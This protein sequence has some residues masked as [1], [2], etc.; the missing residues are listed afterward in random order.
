MARMRNISKSSAEY[1][2]GFTAF[3]GIAPLGDHSDK[4][5]LA[6]VENMFRSYE[7]DSSGAIESVPGYRRLLSPEEG[8]EI[9]GVYST[10]H[11][12]LIHIGEGLYHA[13]LAADRQ[14]LD[15][16]HIGELES[17]QSLGF[18]FGGDFYLIDGK[19]VH[20]VG[21]SAENEAA[22]ASTDGTDTGEVA[23]AATQATDGTDTGEVTGAATL[24]TDGTD[25]PIPV[26]TEAEPY[27]PTTGYGGEPYEKRN[28][29]T[30]RFIEEYDIFDGRGY[31]AASEGLRFSVTD[32]VAH[33][34]ALSGADETVGGHLSIPG[35]VIIDGV[36][37]R[38]D[39]ISNGAFRENEKITSVRIAEGVRRIGASAFL[40]CAELTR[41]STP[42]TIEIIDDEALSLC[43]SLTTVYLGRSL[44]YLGLSLFSD[45]TGISA[46]HYPEG[47]PR[48]KQVEGSTQLL[49]YRLVFFS[50]DESIDIELPL[51][52]TPL[53]VERVTADGAELEFW[54]ENSE[55]RGTRVK[56]SP[57]THWEHN[58]KK[59]LIEGTLPPLYSS[60]DGSG[61]V[62]KIRGGDAILGCTVSGV[63]DGRVFLSGN[64]E[65][66]NTVFYSSRTRDGG[67]SAVYFGVHSYFN[68]G[69][70]RSRVS[71]MLAVGDSLAVFKT[72]DDGV[73]SI[74]YHKSAATGDDL[75]PTVYPV[76]SVH[77]GLEIYGRAIS[78]M[79]EAHLLTPGGLMA[80]ERQAI[81]L[82]RSI[83][84][85]STNVNAYLLREDLSRAVLAP[86]MGYIAVCVGRRIFLGDPRA[87][88]VGPR[89]N[90]EYEWFIIDGVGASVGEKD[91]YRFESLCPLNG[92]YIKEDS[93]GEVF[94]GTV[95]STTVSGRKYYYGRVD[96]RA[97]A[98]YRTAEKTREGLIPA[99]GYYAVD[100][101]LW[102]S[103]NGG[104]YAFN[105]DMRGISPR[106]VTDCDTGG[107]I[108]PYFYSFDGVAPRYALRTVR[109]YCSI[110]HLTKSTVKSSAVVKYRAA[111]AGRILYEVGTDRSGYRE[112]AEIYGSGI[113][114]SEI[115]F[116][117]LTLSP[118]TD[119]TMPIKEAERG[120]V[121]KDIG[122]YS[123]A[124]CCPIAI[125]S[126]AYRFKI[127]GRVKSH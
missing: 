3:R 99:D 98:I 92:I 37:H 2:D 116:D 36:R 118:P 71:S 32:P 57:K 48:L 44:S 43:P 80:I 66:P 47:E 26:L 18:S 105:S 65:L 115:D 103:A 16:T 108:H 46:I 81:N 21:L 42:D 127:K 59:I 40:G 20:R 23:G 94:D 1:T 106:G 56:I 55:K 121:E 9:H 27:V 62:G 90:L 49:N 67:V 13:A 41:I 6:Y 78:F 17:R 25:K 102:F 70:G 104:L 76:T 117:T 84:C 4:S 87:T 113:D 31:A 85:R 96:G 93:L 7:S 68:D 58:G 38:V 91:V 22:G 5:R 11:G 75:L 12:E 74:F 34:C 100:G 126:L 52:V 114:F 10:P 35:Y 88:F 14:S 83:S 64:P 61:E 19:S 73:G 45:S 122:V 95:Y 110:P 54:V 53:S 111:S 119:V 51:S 60:F 63:Y 69:V 79:D 86:F 107:R 50:A 77:T 112:M 39:E 28:L 109:S 72:E 125:Y 120:W 33:L 15:L 123:Q 89:G 24:A 8:G 30:D 82:E 101:M 29:L 97:Y 124:F